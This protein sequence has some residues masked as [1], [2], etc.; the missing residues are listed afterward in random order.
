MQ[1]SNTKYHRLTASLIVICLLLAGL[2]MQLLDG[3]NG[4]QGAPGTGTG[5]VALTDLPGIQLA[6]SRPAP[7]AGTVDFVTRPMFSQDRRPAK[8]LV[9]QETSKPAASQAA[10]M[11]PDLELMGTLVTSGTRH[12]LFWDS[13]SNIAVRVAEGESV[14][15]WTVSEIRDKQVKISRDEESYYYSLPDFNQ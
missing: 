13:K 4:A 12:A 2:I 11:K 3:Q 8:E 9:Q 15:G 14:A 10:V 6:E 1:Q 5:K 7:A